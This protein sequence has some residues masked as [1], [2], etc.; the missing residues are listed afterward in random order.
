MPPLHIKTIT[1]G[2]FKDVLS[3]YPAMVPEKLRDLD[4]QRY[5]IIRKAVAAQDES[6]KHLTKEQVVTLVEWKLYGVPL[7]RDNMKH[8]TFRPALL[9]LVQ[10]NTP[11]AVEKTTKKAYAALWKSKSSQPDA[12]PALKILVGLKGVGP[13][14]AS[15]L[16]SVLRPAEIPFFS[17][18]LFRWSVWDDETGNGKDGKGWQRKIKY[19]VKEYEMML[20]RVHELRKRLRRGFGQ[21]DPLAR[22][23]D[24][25]RVAW[26]LGKEGVDVSG[27]EDETEEHEGKDADVQADT[28]AE[29]GES[30]KDEAQQEEIPAVT[31][32]GSGNEATI[33][34]PVAKKGT[35]RKAS[36]AKPPVEGTRKSTRTKK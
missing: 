9:G 27:P 36:E 34:K 35:K 23:I 3:R 12:I 16:L 11:E 31:K 20:D 6:E 30:E 25:E 32:E 19:N 8:G 21:R 22:A 5:D 15:L 4:A 33:A 7:N 14:T 17:D 26:V 13:A 2:A 18:E 28:K 1:L 29:E 10:S 24:V